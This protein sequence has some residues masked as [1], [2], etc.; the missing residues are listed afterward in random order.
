MENGYKITDLYIAA[1]I[2]C[3]PGMELQS[4]EQTGEVDMRGRKRVFFVVAGSPDRIKAVIDAFFN[5][6]YKI[7]AQLFKSK[8]QGLKSRLHGDF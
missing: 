2:L 6:K 3:E 4:I 5:A 7:D 1:S 8:L